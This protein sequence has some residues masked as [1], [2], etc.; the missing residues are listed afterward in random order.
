[1][2]TTM[3]AAPSAADLGVCPLDGCSLEGGPDEFVTCSRCREMLATDEAVARATPETWAAYLSAGATDTDPHDAPLSRVQEGTQMTEAADPKTF[4][5]AEVGDLYRSHEGTWH[6]ILA[7][8][9]SRFEYAPGQFDDSYRL[10]CEGTLADGGTP[11]I[12]AGGP[13]ARLA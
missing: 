9:H 10:E 11:V 7:I 2:L 5:Q 8:K 12:A 13:K 4:E 3:A 1:M 6:R